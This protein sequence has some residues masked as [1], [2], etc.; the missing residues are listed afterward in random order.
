MIVAEFHQHLFSPLK[1][2]VR[3]DMNCANLQLLI[4]FS[5]AGSSSD[6][7]E[8]NQT[9]ELNISAWSHPGPIQKGGMGISTSQ[10]LC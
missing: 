2:Q 5:Q 1:P 8:L 7:A 9:D 4:A 3:P 10:S 6:P